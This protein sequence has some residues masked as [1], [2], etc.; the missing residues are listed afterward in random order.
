MLD[1]LV[2]VRDDREDVE[3][4]GHYQHHA[5]PPRAFHIVGA[6]RSTQ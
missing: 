6:G 2:G 3:P 4:V 5:P 1:L